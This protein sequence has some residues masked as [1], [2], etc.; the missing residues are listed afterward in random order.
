MR[1]VGFHYTSQEGVTQVHEFNLAP[2]YHKLLKTIPELNIEGVATPEEAGT[3]WLAGRGTTNMLVD[4]DLNQALQAVRE[5]GSWTPEMLKGIT[6]VVLGNIN[7]VL[8]SLTD[9]TP[10]SGGRCA[11][12]AAAEDTDSPVD[13]GV[14]AGSAVGVLSTEGKVVTMVVV[15][16]P[17]KLEGISAREALGGRP[18]TWLWCRNKFRHHNR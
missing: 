9:R 17:V 10:L 4:L 6:P 18:E 8:L 3:L 11:F 5:G 14:V 16:R 12:T 1:G 13:D 7:K 2:L 15:D